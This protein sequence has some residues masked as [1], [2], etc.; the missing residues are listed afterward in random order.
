MPAS[1][2]PGPV[3]T[4]LECATRCTSGQP[5]L[6]VQPLTL[7]Q[8]TLAQ[9]AAPIIAQHGAPTGVVQCL[10]MQMRSLPPP[11]QLLQEQHAARG[12]LCCRKAKP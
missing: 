11:Q 1:S 3:H 7:V 10:L 12:A 9:L 8:L 6:D 4:I 2:G 5:K